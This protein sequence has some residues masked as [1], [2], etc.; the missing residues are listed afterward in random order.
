[1]LIL[2]PHKQQ[3]GIAVR[4]VVEEAMRSLHGDILPQATGGGIIVE[5]GTRHIGQLQQAGAAEFPFRG[6]EPFPADGTVARTEQVEKIT[7]PKGSRGHV[8]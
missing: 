1:M 6:I 4:P 3:M 8:G 2:Q 5:V 7:K